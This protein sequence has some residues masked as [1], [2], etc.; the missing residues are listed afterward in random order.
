MLYDFL[1]ANNSRFFWAAATAIIL[2]CSDKFFSNEFESQNALGNKLFRITSNRFA[3]K[4][5][6]LIAKQKKYV[7]CRRWSRLKRVREGEN[8]EFVSK[9]L[10]ILELTTGDLWLIAGLSMHTRDYLAKIRR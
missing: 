4:H 8:S 6:K 10:L 7:D 1:I 2:I 3:I 9:M 5:K